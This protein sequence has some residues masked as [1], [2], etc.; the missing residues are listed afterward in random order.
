MY[1]IRTTKT[2]SGAIAVQIVRYENRKLIVVKHIGSGHTADEILG[3]RHYAEKWILEFSKQQGLF[4]EETKTHTSQLIGL[5]KCRYLGIRYT[6]IYDVLRSLTA[7]FKFLSCVDTLLLDL[8]IIRLIEPASKLQS[9]E[10]LKEYF[11]IKHRRQIFYEKLP[12]YCAN[13]NTIEKLVT[14]FAVKEFSFD[15]SIVFYDVTTLYFES[16]KS[17]A[18]RKPGF[19]KDG[20]SNQPQ[21]IVGLM[22]NNLGFPVGYEMFKGNKFEG[23]TMIPVIKDFCTK[24]NVETMTVVTDAAMISIENIEALKTKKLSYIVGARTAN[25]SIVQIRKIAAHLRRR[26]GATIRIQTKHGTLICSFS[27][28][29]ESKDRHEMEKQLKKAKFYLKNPALMKKTR[30][31]KFAGKNGFEINK[32]V[33]E[34]AKLLLGIKGYYTNLGQEIEDRIV[35]GHYKNL[36]HVE[37]AFRIAKNDLETRP[38]YHSKKEAISV[39]LL[40]CFM[41]L[42]ISKYI[43]IKTDKSL[44]HVI[45]K[46]MKITDADILDTLS[47]KVFTMRSQIPPEVFDY[48]SRLEVPY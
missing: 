45:R 22:V 47:Q 48:L 8:V 21:I 11:N 1:H 28:K 5:D 23:H 36:W 40:I 35:I 41:A 34:K 37:Q 2:A 7:K 29:R 27:A 44:K 16:F 39:H 13:K 20:K 3:L 43:E 25:L 33:K 10:L 18:L 32:E 26:D 42:A 38:I 4:D 24:N 31:L 6:F 17:D 30:F 46:F 9:F 14:D 15:Y 12:Y 19:S